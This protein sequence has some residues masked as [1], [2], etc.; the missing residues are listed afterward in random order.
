MIKLIDEY[1][2]EVSHEAAVMAIDLYGVIEDF[3]GYIQRC[4]VDPEFYSV[5]RIEGIDES[6][7]CVGDFSDIE[8]TKAYAN[9]LCEK[10]R[11]GM[12]DNGIRDTERR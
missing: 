3:D 9:Q 11:V 6:Y 1:D 2:I 4:D 7:V 8:D 10:Y 12:V 5:Y